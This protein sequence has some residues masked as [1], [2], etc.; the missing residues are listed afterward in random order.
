MLLRATEHRERSGLQRRFVGSGRRD[1]NPG[2]L[3]RGWMIGGEREDE[4]G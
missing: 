1:E 2:W 4:V 3:G